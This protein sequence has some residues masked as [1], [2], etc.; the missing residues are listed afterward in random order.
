MLQKIIVK[1]M[2]T[3]LLLHA[4]DADAEQTL[5]TFTL[6]DVQARVAQHAE[7]K[8][9]VDLSSAYDGSDHCAI[10]YGWHDAVGNYPVL[11]FTGTPGQTLVGWINIGPRTSNWQPIKLMLV[12]DDDLKAVDQISINETDFVMFRLT[13][14]LQSQSNRFTLLMHVPDEPTNGHLILAD[15]HLVADLPS[16]LPAVK[17]RVLPSTDLPHADYSS[18]LIRTFDGNDFDPHFDAAMDLMGMNPVTTLT[19]NHTREINV[20][21][22][23][24]DPPRVIPVFS[25]DDP[26]ITSLDYA[27][28]GQI[29]YGSAVGGFRLDVSQ[30]SVA[31]DLSDGA[32]EDGGY[33]EMISDFADGTHATCRAQAD[34][35]LLREIRGRSGPRSFLLPIHSTGKLPVRIRMNLCMNGRGTVSISNLQLVQYSPPVLTAHTN[36]PRIFNPRLLWIPAMVLPFFCLVLAM[37]PMVRRG[38]GRRIVMGWIWI[39]FVFAQIAFAWC[40]A[41]WGHGVAFTEFSPPL[42]IS[43]MVLGCTL[44][45]SRRMGR[46]Y[47]DAELKRM[48]LMDAV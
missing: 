35:G 37:E 46:R 13:V 15:M 39:S 33:L 1:A 7:S 31:N 2:C 36:S 32:V 19:G 14:P 43:V 41:A 24:C 21:V 29:S 20:L 48:Q 44:F 10:D 25:V 18:R 27:V 16:T 22:P 40:M 38:K 11:S 3:I 26:G 28:A 5:R 45:A 42:L 23:S 34:S 47:Q 8:K 4:A 6:A 9:H 30:L 12:Y 17:T